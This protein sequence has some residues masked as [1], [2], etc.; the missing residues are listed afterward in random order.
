MWTQEYLVCS[1]NLSVLQGTAENRRKWTGIT[2]PNRLA[3]MDMTWIVKICH[4]YVK[5]LND[6]TVCC[7]ASPRSK[8]NVCQSEVGVWMG[9]Q[10]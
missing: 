6:T 1:K 5:A 10:E 7:V 4:G 9:A 2:K 8:T 3:G